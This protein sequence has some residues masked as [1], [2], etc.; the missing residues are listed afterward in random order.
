MPEPRQTL[1]LSLILL[2]AAGLSV[3]GCARLAN[4]PLNP[5]NWFGRAQVVEA[6]PVRDRRSLVPPG[7]LTVVSD[8]RRPV[9]VIADMEI[10]RSPSGAVLRATG[11]AATQGYYNAELVLIGAEGRTLVYELRAERPAGFEA[12]GPEAT[13]RIT[14]ARA[15]SVQDLRGVSAIRVQ[16]AQNA[17]VARR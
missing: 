16:G 2:V 12:I 10:A 11:L 13:R 3:T 17:R 14:A 6:A 4:S 15:L 1:R 5:G 8:T 9:E 7:R